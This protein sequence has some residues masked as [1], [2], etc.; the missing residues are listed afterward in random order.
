MT[1]ASRRTAALTL[2]AALAVPLLSA[3]TAAPEPRELEPGA[4][5]AAAHNRLPDRESVVA[6][7]EPHRFDA[8]A[9]LGEW[10]DAGAA[11]E[12]A[13]AGTV[14][15][16]VVRAEPGDE[17]AAAFRDWAEPRCASAY[18]GLLGVDDL[19]LGEAAGESLGLEPALGAT[20]VAG[21]GSRGAFVAGDRTVACALAWIDDGGALREVAY[22]DGVT[23]A[24]ALGATFPLELRSCVDLG[25]D[26]V[27]SAAP[28]PDAHDGQVLAT[29][30]ARAA[31]GAEWIAAVDP[32]TGRAADYGPADE[33]C[34]A[35]A[36]R[37]VPGGELPEHLEPWA[38]I[39]PTD[40]WVGFDGAVAD[41]ARYPVSCSV[42]GADERAIT[43]D[44]LAGTTALAG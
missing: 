4:C 33:A 2:G 24:D 5:V 42:V 35:L 39:S 23:V 37:L 36:T 16:R 12:A 40:G 14:Y 25:P 11:I 44:V 26:G 7:T 29:V 19:A 31:L 10:P 41:G 22:P 28:C 3:C 21:F 13:D 34:R 20:L 32:A 6:C 18:R 15:D 9:M 38:D 30:D 43:G 17:L 8:V 1:R 27:R